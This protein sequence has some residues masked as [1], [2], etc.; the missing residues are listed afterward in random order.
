MLNEV[1]TG[2][3]KALENLREALAERFGEEGSRQFTEMLQETRETVVDLCRERILE[4]LDLEAWQAALAWYRARGRAND[5]DECNLILG[6]A[7]ALAT[8]L[9][10]LRD[11]GRYRMTYRML[12]LD[13]D[14]QG[15]LQLVEQTEV[16]PNIEVV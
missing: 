7:L 4:R 16:A 5:P 2:S 13:R 11:D 6:I 1:R 9:R 12:V 14:P 8:Q 15:Y 3:R 10:W